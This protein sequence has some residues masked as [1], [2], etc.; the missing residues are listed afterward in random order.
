MKENI[1]IKVTSDKL[2]LQACND[3]VQDD[4]C[5]GIALFVGT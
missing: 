4:A 5:G 1:S 3:F 2:N